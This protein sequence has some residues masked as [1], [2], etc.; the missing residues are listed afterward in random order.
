MDYNEKVMDHFLNPRNTGRIENP[1]GVGEVG[2]PKCG[3]VMKIY[4]NVKGNTISEITFETFGCA[5]AIATSSVATELVEGKS[6]QQA[7]NLRNKDIIDY[8]GGLPVAKLHCSV[9]AEQGIKA[10]ISD[11]Y[12]KQGIDPEVVLFNTK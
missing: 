12:K 7:F 3:D 10:A 8:L 9:L 6:I 1:D 2:N 11:F 5:A 4:I